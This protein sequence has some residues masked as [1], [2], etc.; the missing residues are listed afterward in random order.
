MAK[1]LSDKQVADCCRVTNVTGDLAPRLLQMGIV[2]GSEVEI[3][4]TAPLGFPM[5]IKIRGYSLSLRE[6]EAS[7]IEIES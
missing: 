3:I 2:P 1:T 7:C 6:E 4:R 5:E